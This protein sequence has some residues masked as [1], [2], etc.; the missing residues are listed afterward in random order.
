MSGLL[1]DASS[2]SIRR[3]PTTGL[4]PNPLR[5]PF[6]LSPYLAH[7]EDSD[8]A[9]SESYGKSSPKF[10][11]SFHDSASHS[12]SD[13]V[14]TPVYNKSYKENK[15]LSHP[16]I[17]SHSRSHEVETSSPPFHTVPLTPEMGRRAPSIQGNVRLSR[18][19]IASIPPRL[20]TPDFSLLRA[21]L[22]QALVAP[23][24]FFRSRSAGQSQQSAVSQQTTSSSRSHHIPSFLSRLTPKLREATRE[25]E[26]PTFKLQETSSLPSYPVLWSPTA[27]TADGKPQELGINLTVSES[28]KETYLTSISNS[29]R[30]ER[31]ALF[32]SVFVV[33]ESLECGTIGGLIHN[34]VFIIGFSGLFY[35]LL[36]WLRAIG[37]SSMVVITQYDLS[38]CENL[39]KDPRPKLSNDL[40]TDITLIS[41]MHLVTS[42]VGFMGAFLFS[43]TVVICYMVLLLPNAAALLMIGCVA[44]Q[45]CTFSLAVYLS[46]LWAGLDSNARDVILGTVS[47][48]MAHRE[49]H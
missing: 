37:I 40:R 6:S 49:L 45:R 42:V 7:E 14:P 33:S 34:Q 26:K 11:R 13:D 44:Y 31:G 8:L 23:L 25:S 18:S 10:P 17:L 30:W 9:G 5:S 47:A 12:T 36:L 21:P 3:R 29:W 35:S 43:R 46:R 38:L 24:N 15:S 2:T 28:G 20:P 16:S 41:S 1:G 19:T 27:A 48:S 39:L 4:S 22:R 32:L